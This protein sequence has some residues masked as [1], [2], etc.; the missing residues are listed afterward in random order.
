VE[1]HREGVAGYRQHS[2]AVYREKELLEEDHRE[3][4]AGYRQRSS[5]VNREHRVVGGGS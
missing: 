1:D 3:G 5:A 2:S 4:A